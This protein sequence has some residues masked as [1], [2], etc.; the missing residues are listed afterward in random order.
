MVARA[1]PQLGNK[2]VAAI[3]A[4]MVARQKKVNWQCLMDIRLRTVPL[5]MRPVSPGWGPLSASKWLALAA[6]SMRLPTSM[7]NCSPRSVARGS[8]IIGSRFMRLVM[9]SARG[10]SVNRLAARQSIQIERQVRLQRSVEPA[11]LSGPSAMPNLS[12]LCAQE[13]TSAK[14]VDQG[15]VRAVS[16]QTM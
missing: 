2:T 13:Q 3:R 7:T 14:R 10:C 8:K 6:A 15:N 11:A 9:R 16:L 5:R 4:R 12:P 1:M